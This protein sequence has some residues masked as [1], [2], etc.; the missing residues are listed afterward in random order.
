MLKT[1]KYS[2]CVTFYPFTKEIFNEIT[3]MC[4]FHY[5]ETLTQTEH[6][7]AP[8]FLQSLLNRQLAFGALLVYPVLFYL[9]FY[10]LTRTDAILVMGLTCACLS[11]LSYGA[12]L[13]AL[14]RF[15]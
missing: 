13:A 10:A 5:L 11:V 14:V 1:F 9:R 7:F 15:C 12:P 3:A 6:Y 4:I 2:G 8:C